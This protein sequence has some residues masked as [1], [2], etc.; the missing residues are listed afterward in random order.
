[1]TAV[2][3]LCVLPLPP[4]LRR[5]PDAVLLILAGVLVGRSRVA[6]LVIHSGGGLVR[7]FSTVCQ[8]TFLGLAQLHGWAFKI[9]VNL[10]VSSC[11]GI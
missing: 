10:A 5:G 2:W 7:S 11:I 3:T 6:G 1:M 8:S 9:K 4:P